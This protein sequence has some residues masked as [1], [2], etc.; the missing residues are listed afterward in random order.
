MGVVGT[1]EFGAFDDPDEGGLDEECP[2]VK[3]R[4]PGG[5]TPVGD[6][7]RRTTLAAP[8]GSSTGALGLVLAV[9]TSS[10]MAP[11]SALLEAR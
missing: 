6:E 2:L 7:G 1:D 11:S 5:A 8:L 9:R 3:T 10:L 4:G